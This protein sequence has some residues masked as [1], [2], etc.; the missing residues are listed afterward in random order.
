[1][2]QITVTL[3]DID[4]LKLFD[5]DSFINGYHVSCDVYGLRGVSDFSLDMIMDLRKKTKKNIFVNVNKLIHNSELKD[6]EEYIIKLDTIGVDFI[7]FGDFAVIQIINENNLKIKSIYCTETTITNKYFTSMAKE[8]GITGIDT[9]KEITL[10]EVDNICKN[11]QSLV[12]MNIHGHIYMYQSKRKLI[13]NYKNHTGLDIDV[14]DNYKLYD[15]ERDQSYPIIENKQGTHLLASHDVML[16][17]HLDKLVD[18]DLDF[19]KIDGFGYEKCDFEAIVNLYKEAFVSIETGNYNGKEY[20]K[21]LRE[22]V[23]YKDFDNGF[24]FKKTMY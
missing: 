15:P 17:N 1:M 20:A 2:K 7:V 9:A 21:R 19:M 22:L 16:I 23:T 4:Q 18:I 5:Q 14:T 11:K 10:S 13:T 12:S 8:T 6:L 3:F 24:F